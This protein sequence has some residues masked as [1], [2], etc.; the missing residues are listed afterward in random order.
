MCQLFESRLLKTEKEREDSKEEQKKNSLGL[1]LMFDWFLK[2]CHGRKLVAVSPG[3]EEAGDR[4]TTDKL[5]GSGLCK[6]S[7]QPQFIWTASTRVLV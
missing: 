5:H 1:N 3:G 6:A 7:V 2:G 4:R